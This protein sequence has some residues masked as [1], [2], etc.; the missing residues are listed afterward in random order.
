MRNTASLLLLFGMTTAACGGPSVDVS[1]GLQVL[2]IS[3]AWQDVGI[4]DGQNKIVPTITFKVKNVS[5]QKL[6][7]L[8]LNLLFRRITEPNEEW[9]S[10]FVISPAPGGLAPGQT[11][12]RI[13][14]TS[15]LGYKGTEPREQLLK[16]SQF[17]DAKVDLFAKYASVQWK[18][19]GE[20]PIDRQL[21]LQ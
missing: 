10:A 5:D 14:A 18:K 7:G 21:I 9:G 11:S 4:V 6:T 8:Q 16:N 15:Q 12:E 2:D 13:T 20:F 1:K 17:V 3:T 19:V